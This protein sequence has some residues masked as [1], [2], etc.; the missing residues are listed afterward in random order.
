MCFR[1]EVESI[2]YSTGSINVTPKV[3]TEIPHRDRKK[4]IG[5]PFH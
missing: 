4:V 2:S 5:Q 1:Q 3:D